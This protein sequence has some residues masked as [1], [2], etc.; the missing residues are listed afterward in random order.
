VEAADCCSLYLVPHDGRKLPSFRP[1]QFLTIS[2]NV[3][4]QPRPLVRCYS[5][6]EAPHPDYYR[7]TIKKVP[8]PVGRSDLSSGRVSSHLID[9]VQDG[10][11][12]DV[13]APSGAF[14]LDLDQP[15]PTVLIGGG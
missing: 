8:P 1:G 6:S 12:L 3:P 15:D 4:G 5:L 9:F 13:R 14:Y 7:C 2:V 10:D 11:L